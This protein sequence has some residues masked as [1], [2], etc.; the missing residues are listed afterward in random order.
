[1]ANQGQL[2]RAAWAASILPPP[3]RHMK[4]RGTSPKPA[5]SLASDSEYLWLDAPERSTDNPD[6]PLMCPVALAA[7]GTVV[8][9]AV[10]SSGP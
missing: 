6:A 7:C 8:V 1:M 5:N 2:D 9:G 4:D 3:Q 10:L